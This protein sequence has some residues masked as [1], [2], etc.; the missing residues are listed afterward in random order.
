MIQ[1]EAVS[2][3][4]CSTKVDVI[5][6]HGTQGRCSLSEAEQ[7]TRDELPAVTEASVH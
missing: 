7:E 2:A 5:M 4:A 1:G 3:A 6:T